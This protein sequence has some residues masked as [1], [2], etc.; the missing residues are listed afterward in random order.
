MD[1]KTGTPESVSLS[2]QSI[3]NVINTLNNKGIPMHSLLIMKDDVLAFETYYSPINIDSNHRMFSISK[4]LTAL[5]I[6]ALAD[7][8]KIDLDDSICDYFK[9][10]VNESTHEYIRNTTIRDCLMMRTC[11]A[12][13]TYKLGKSGWVES[14]FTV[15]PTH[16]SGTVFHYDTSSSHTLAALV[17]KLT[18]MKMLT[19][20]KH[21]FK[22]L[23]ISEHSFMI[24]D[25]QGVSMGGSGLCGTSRDI[26]K[27]GYLLMHEGNING[28][29]LLSA[30][31]IRQATSLLTETAVTG[32]V[33]SEK[34]GY[35]Y[36]I[37]RTERNGYVLYGMGGQLVICMPDINMII[38]TTADTQ[39]I[40]GGNQIIYDTLYKEIVDPLL[41]GISTPCTGNDSAYDSLCTLSSSLAI[42]PVTG[43]TH[44][45]VID[46]YNGARFTCEDDVFTAVTINFNDTPKQ[47]FVIG[48]EP[49][50]V[51]T[52]TLERK[53]AAPVSL[54]FGLGHMC[55]GSFPGYDQFYCASGAFLRDGSLYVKFHILDEYCGSVHMQFYFN[56]D[57]LTVFMKK[58]EESL[59]SEYNRHLNCT[60][61]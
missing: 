9:E 56:D 23:D 46:R 49:K 5:C 25:P 37:W 36:F 61:A 1:F 26:L 31:Y 20:F 50:P 10:Y 43:D 28:K 7:E 53:A 39:G 27:L 45:T 21:K 15:E 44:S 2:S 54:N 52:I 16:R 22:E 6:G 32:P 35:G 38:V 11:H 48:E 24:T 55:N 59:F 19:F 3:I 18:G 14:F 30:D 47:S 33:A 41:N 17:E 42:A 4:T 12:S 60:I 8:G 29:Q 13:T 51:C 57:T 58:I 34:Q 40:G